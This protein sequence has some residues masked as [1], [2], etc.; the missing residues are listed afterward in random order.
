MVPRQTDMAVHLGD[1]AAVLKLEEGWENYGPQV[2]Q[3]LQL[4][5]QGRRY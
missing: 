3:T 4:Q 5:H 2:L 1:P